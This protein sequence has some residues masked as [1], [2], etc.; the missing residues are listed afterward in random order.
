MNKEFFN[1]KEGDIALAYDEYSRDALIHRVRI[2]NVEYDEENVC[3]ENPRGMTC[4][5]E[6]VDEAKWD[7][8][9]VTVVNHANFIRKIKVVE[10]E[11]GNVVTV[12]DVTDEDYYK[13]P[14]ITYLD[15]LEYDCWDLFKKY[16]EMI[17]ADFPE[18][19]EKEFGPDFYM[20]KQIQDKIIE[21]VEA[22]FGVPFPRSKDG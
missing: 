11:S 12:E 2:N 21:L 5:G 9:Y 8:D 18:E 13:N 22:K 19:D 20:A 10:M 1:L 15:D 14:R 3:E 6:D 16:A 7:D 4:Y 17:G